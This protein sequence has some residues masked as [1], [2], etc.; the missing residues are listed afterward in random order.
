MFP[1]ALRI[2]DWSRHF[3]NNRTRDLKRMG[4]VCVPNKMDGDG[5][6]ELLD[7][8]DGDRHYACWIALLQVASKCD[9]R[10]TLLRDGDRPHDARSICRISR[11]RIEVMDAAIERLISIGWLERISMAGE[12]VTKIPQ[13]GAG[14]PQVG[15]EKHP[16]NGME[17]NGMER[18]GIE[19]DCSEPSKATDS[20]PPAEKP[21][22]TVVLEFPVAGKGNPTWGLSASKVAEY[23]ETYPDLDLTAEL[24]KARQWCI[25]NRENRKTASGMLRF[26]N[27][28]LARAQNDRGVRAGQ[29]TAVPAGQDIFAGL[30]E[31][32]ERRMAADDGR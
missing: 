4:F 3:E 2:V 14:K 12:V 16:L 15:A 28:W 20:K 11:M 30:R 21:T 25:D 32:R 7:H 29:R 10:G 5:Y 9:P 13:E 6:T 19:E 23:A 27:R 31:S 26:L 17:W 8:A 18:N 22:D 1:T 24:R